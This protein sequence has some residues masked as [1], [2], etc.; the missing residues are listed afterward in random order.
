M[1]SIYK[2]LLGPK[3]LSL[4][5]MDV[6]SGI[7][8][9]QLTE[10]ELDQLISSNPLRICILAKR[11]DGIEGVLKQYIC[12]NGKADEQDPVSMKSV[13]APYQLLE[14]A[15][16]ISPELRSFVP[17]FSFYRPQ[18]E[19]DEEE[20][21]WVFNPQPVL[22]TL[23][24]VLA[25]IRCNPQ[26]DAEKNLVLILRIM[27]N[28]AQCLQALHHCGLVHRD[29]KPHN[30][31][32][33]TLNGQILPDTLCLFDVD[34]VCR[35]DA[36][37]EGFAG[38]P[39]YAEPEAEYLQPGVQS[40]IYSFGQTFYQALIMDPSN[41]SMPM[42]YSPGKRVS[43]E[44]A[45]RESPLIACSEINSY[46]RLRNCLAGILMKCLAF[47]DRRYQNYEKLIAD[48][49]DALLYALPAQAAAM[50]KAGRAWRFEEVEKYYQTYR[51]TNSALSIGLHLWQ[52]P[53]FSAENP[54]PSVLPVLILGFGQYGQK[55]MDILLQTCQI[56]ECR[57][58][59]TVLSNDEKDFELYFQ[60]RSAL[61]PMLQI[62]GNGDPMLGNVQILQEE[63]TGT[64][65]QLMRLS[66]IAGAKDAKPAVFCA[67]GDDDFSYDAACMLLRSDYFEAS[68]V[69]SI[70]QQEHQPFAQ[71]NAGQT[72]WLEELF[73]NN[74]DLMEE[75]EPQ[76][77]S[78]WKDP[79]LHPDYAP[80]MRMAFNTHLSWERN[81][82]VSWQSLRSAF[83]DP[84]YQTASILYVLAL[85][86]RLIYAGCGLEMHTIR[87]AAALFGKKLEAD[88]RLSEA[89]SECEHRRWM[90]EK[91]CQGWAA[92]TDLERAVFHGRIN[93]KAK[94][95]VCLVPGGL[96]AALQ[97]SIINH[98]GWLWDQAPAQVIEQLDPL[99]QVSVGMHRIALREA[100]KRH[101]ENLSHQQYLRYLEET[102]R[103]HPEI[104]NAWTAW[105]QAVE[106]IWQKNPYG[107]SLIEARRQAFANALKQIGSERAEQALFALDRFDEWFGVQVESLRRYDWKEPDRRLLRHIPF[108]LTYL[109]TLWM[110]ICIDQQQVARSLWPARL[111]AP[112]KL[113]VFMELNRYSNPDVLEDWMD[114]IDR[115]AKEH[116][117]R[118][119]PEYIIVCASYME[120]P[121]WAKAWIHNLPD[122]ERVH[123]M[124][125]DEHEWN[126]WLLQAEEKKMVLAD[127]A[128]PFFKQLFE[129]SGFDRIGF[130]ED[131]LMMRFQECE[132]IFWRR[133]E[134]MVSIMDEPFWHWK[135]PEGP[136]VR[137]LTDELARLYQKKSWP[138]FSKLAAQSDLQANRPV[139]HFVL[140]DPCFDL[141]FEKGGAELSVSCTVNQEE[142]MRQLS[143]ILREAGLL[144][145]PVSFAYGNGWRMQAVFRLSGHENAQELNRMIA[146]LLTNKIDLSF[147]RVRTKEEWT[148]I[149]VQPETCRIELPAALDARTDEFVFLA[150]DLARVGLLMDLHKSFESGSM[151]MEWAWSCRQAADLVTDFHAVCRLILWRALMA[152]DRFYTVYSN[153]ELVMNDR[154]TP[155]L[156]DFATADKERIWLIRLDPA[157]EEWDGLAEL[158]SQ[159]HCPVGILLVLSDGQNIETVNQWLAE[160]EDGPADCMVQVC[161]LER[162]TEWME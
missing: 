103:M 29:I 10:F 153:E 23:D 98:D 12:Q 84:Y 13:L 121:I 57:L 158:A 140:T 112:R 59:I 49:D 152:D 135:A 63:F 123:L 113:S 54:N 22:K 35:N 128:R 108:I 15:R 145:Q 30:I 148:E 90:A 85:R 82:N 70:E 137:L 93:K 101:Q 40:D 118:A 147:L 53:L 51:K 134:E 45:L 69:I 52:H 156:F 64:R 95:H 102:A 67:L 71:M 110:G 28:L 9:E 119:R 111:A 80:L 100:Q 8:Q 50:Q 27:K 105:R 78:L 104:M 141:C 77:L 37:D 151:K 157:Q 21:I 32:F 34:T 160:T 107:V 130:E 96:Q 154:F 122:P 99:D 138:L 91:L 33:R 132:P 16:Q 120:C 19:E 31:G 106:I 126:V 127:H 5:W 42:F 73:E 72:D 41:P 159:F 17:D 149:S 117:F 86:N 68:Q 129:K 39:H 3:H 36:E 139:F 26:Q 4:H 44:R 38:T 155:S 65:A 109:P 11:Q 46:A 25:Q 146:W 60:E 62:N 124:M 89:L 143:G 1:K 2:N 74:P 47:R 66:R 115:Y 56:P 18:E 131:A 20:R 116:A 14:K 43:V 75:E 7:E 125:A 94:E 114:F 58:Q 161:P 79:I 83:S 136:D 61:A 142:W 92:M 144:A 97:D 48:L 81:L 55:I 88:D 162:M 76:I 6:N 133:K 150:D 24:S 87:Q